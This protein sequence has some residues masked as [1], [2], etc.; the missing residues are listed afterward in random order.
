MK[1]DKKSTPRAHRTRGTGIAKE[2]SNALWNR[3]GA[4]VDEDEWTLK[5]LD[6]AAPDV[7]TDGCSPDR[8]RDA[9]GYLT[10]RSI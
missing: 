10:T 2:H 1:S 4:A 5:R 9:H 3:Q 7:K 8:A 6:E